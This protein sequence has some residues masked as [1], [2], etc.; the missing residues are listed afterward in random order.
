M[1]F[2]TVLLA[3]CCAAWA[4]VASVDPTPPPPCCDAPPGGSTP[5]VDGEPF[6]LEIGSAEVFPGTTT[7]RV[8]VYLSSTEDVVSWQIGL[9]YEDIILLTGSDTGPTASAAYNPQV[10]ITEPDLSPF[11][12]I[13]VDYDTD[14]EAPTGP[15]PPGTAQHVLDLTFS[16]E[17]DLLPE[18]TTLV[19]LTA[20]EDGALPALINDTISPRLLS[21]EIQIYIGDVVRIGSGEG[22][23]FGKTAIPVRLWSDQP[24]TRFMMGLDYEDVILNG[25]AL[26]GL[27]ES[28]YT[29]EVEATETGADVTLTLLGNATLPA[30]QNQLVFDLLFE[31]SEPR[32]GDVPIH[33]RTAEFAVEDPIPNLISGNVHLLDHF[34]RGD[35]NYD[36]NASLDDAL[37]GLL[38]IAGLGPAPACLA[39]VDANGDDL[40]N[41]ADPI[42]VLTYRFSGGPEPGAP[43]PLPGPDPNPEPVFD[44]LPGE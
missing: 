27:E 17:P 6:E 23:S 1:T 41:I 43:F 28:E 8:P 39:S 44:C 12:G 37:L 4:A 34:V 30:G 16:I 33:L 26:G 29:A 25:I 2:S 36:G 11:W 9:D 7:I 24:E 38:Y 13:R 18:G 22:D 40:I 14:P 19:A 35:F 20:T 42:Y 32:Q 15:L 3:A 10:T 31:V 21:G 5:V